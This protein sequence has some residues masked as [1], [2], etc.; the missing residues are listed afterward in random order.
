MY[1]KLLC[2]FSFLGE[3]IDGLNA[4]IFSTLIFLHENQFSSFSKD[5]SINLLSLNANR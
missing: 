5:I 2:K 1:A 3:R 4:K